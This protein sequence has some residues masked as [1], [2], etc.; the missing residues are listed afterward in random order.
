MVRD[1]R[2]R[3]T[4]IITA[5]LFLVLSASATGMPASAAGQ[6]TQAADVEACYQRAC[7]L[8]VA[9]PRQSRQMSRQAFA[10]ALANDMPTEAAKAAALY[11]RTVMVE[12]AYN[13]GIDLYKTALRHAPHD[14]LRIRADILNGIGWGYTEMG[15]KPKALAYIDSSMVIYKSIGDKGG[16]ASTLNYKGYVY[17]RAGE[18]NLA[19]KAFKSALAIVTEMGDSAKMAAVMSNMSMYPSDD[20]TGR[21]GII[22]EA[23]RINSAMGN[24]FSLGENHNN[25]ARQLLYARQYDEAHTALDKAAAYSKTPRARQ[26]MR[27]NLDIRADVYAAQKDYS[28][29]YA[30]LKRSLELEDEMKA[31]NA[32]QAEGTPYGNELTDI[33]RSV[34]NGNSATGF[35][36]V[37]LSVISVLSI[38]MLVVSLRRNTRYR[39]ALKSHHT[40]VGKERA[41]LQ[42]QLDTLKNELEKARQKASEASDEAAQDR[43]LTKSL[44]FRMAGIGKIIEHAETM[45]RNS[46]RGATPNAG[47]DMRKAYLMLKDTRDSLAESLQDFQQLN[48]QFTERLTARYPTI[49]PAELQLAM[50]ICAGMSAK[51][52]AAAMGTAVKSVGMARYRL[53]KRLELDAEDDLQQF[54]E[55]I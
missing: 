37:F 34:N 42:Q 16:I 17:Y 38:I 8:F 18:Y 19:D 29:A 6:H 41:T 35:P 2:S 7:S 23:I 52:I 4:Y 27:D 26:I 45:T 5:C 15:I 20:A 55:S 25:L 49:S 51:E 50:M 53:R 46:I 11:A 54:L 10:Q 39:R 36:T 24:T 3:L 44:A 9:H 40:N 21:I 32:A 33:E 13:A 22:T 1:S 12:G 31:E 14:S 48:D 28:A 47:A 30:A 43:H